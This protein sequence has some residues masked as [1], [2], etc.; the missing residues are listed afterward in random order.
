MIL[1]FYYIQDSDL[2]DRKY[3]K[4]SHRPQWDPLRHRNTIVKYF[5]SYSITNCN[6][7]QQRA[8]FLI[9]VCDFFSLKS[10][11][12]IGAVKQSR[13]MRRIIFLESIT[14]ILS[15]T[16]DKQLAKNNVKDEIHVMRTCKVLSSEY[17]SFPPKISQN[18][19]GS[20]PSSIRSMSLLLVNH[21]N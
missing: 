6:T 19:R 3:P 8:Y 12:H 4:S 13:W 14:I 16:K 2:P 10:S 21:N 5:N 20:S 9:K 11:S 7:I 18:S 17:F 15:H 1:P